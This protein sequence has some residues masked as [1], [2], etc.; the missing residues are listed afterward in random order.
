[1][2]DYP[3]LVQRMLRWNEPLENRKGIDQHFRM[4]Y[5][6]SAEFEF[7][8]L[9]HSLKAMRAAAGSFIGPK[10]IKSKIGDEYF[11]VWYIGREEEYETAKRFFED[12]LQPDSK[13]R[14]WDL[15]E[16]TDI[17][18]ELGSE[19]HSRWNGK[20]IKKRD[21]AGW[22]SLDTTWHTDASES[23]YYRRD[24]RNPDMKFYP[25]AFFQKKD[26]AALF[27]SL[28]KENGK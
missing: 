19:T 1:M 4:D 16:L 24:F 5:M 13:D 20:P 28:I 9:P 22:W 7:G 11:T 27:L 21:I 3:Y 23:Y 18:A 15:K 17:A 6:G 26:D 2:K 14:S 10:R 25:W 12:Q 8:Q